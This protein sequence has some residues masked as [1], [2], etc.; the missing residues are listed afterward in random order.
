M[1]P[2]NRYIFLLHAAFTVAAGS[3]LTACD[4]LN[5][6]FASDRVNYQNAESGPSLRVP[7]DLTQLKPSQRFDTS[8]NPALLGERTKAK[9]VAASQ[10]QQL[11]HLEYDGSAYWLRAAGYTPEQLWPQLQA[12]WEK[13]GFT[14]K[15]NQPELGLMETDWAENR[16]KIPHSQFRKSIGK[17][18]ENIYSSGTRDKFRTL[19][20]RNENGVAISIIHHGMEEIVIG[21]QDSSRWQDR[22]REPNLEL[23]FFARL[24][25]NLGLNEEQAQDLIKQARQTER[26]TV[27]VNQQAKA[28]LISL[29]ESF[30]RVWW[31]VGLALDRMNFAVEQRD[32]NKGLY[33]GRLIEK[34]PEETQDEAATKESKESKK[35]GLLSQFFNRRPQKISKSAPYQ[36]HIQAV[37]NAKTQIAVV[38]E[39]G[40]IDYTPE[41]QRL[42][43]ALHAQL[44]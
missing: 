13:N 15:V 34:M 22:A 42:I 25:E 43:L 5:E 29:D 14:L 19:V 38:T 35:P 7:T 37:N 16:A 3:L 33:V 24:M 9:R 41:A 40:Q 2:T 31:R 20:Q 11:L 18:L 23:A 30:E 12:L 44:N 17:F 4:T 8:A 10:A 36:I 6:T 21:R 1:K 26:A 39:Q 27:T 32:K 28:T